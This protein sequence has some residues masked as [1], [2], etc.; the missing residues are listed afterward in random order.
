MTKKISLLILSLLYALSLAAAHARSIRYN[1]DP[2]A[3]EQY[4][5][6]VLKLALEKSGEQNLQPQP[7]AEVL[8]ERKVISEVLN[9]TM[10]VYWGPATQENENRFRAIRIPLIKGLL[11]YRLFIINQGDQY[12]FDRIHNLNELKT[13]IAGQGRFWGDTKVLENA[14][15]PLETAVQYKNLFYMLEGGRF[16]YYPRAVH[17]PWSEVK[18]YS[19]LNLAVEKRL[20]LV[21]PL[22]MFFYVNKSDEELAQ[23]IERGFEAAIADGSFNQYFFENE[24][25]QSALAHASLKSRTVI[26]VDNPFLPE[27]TPLDR[28]EFWLDVSAIP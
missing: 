12:K 9:G 19:Q 24:V 16:D 27:S 5:V 14:G 3:K 7:V 17:E 25:I 21:Y 15:L 23:A 22:A 6:G 13:L 26:K 20:M 11:G 1:N 18:D 8:T 4:L 2:A 28:K 10:D